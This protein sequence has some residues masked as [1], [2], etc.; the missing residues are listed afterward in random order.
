M[1]RLA[2]FH[3]SLLKLNPRT[4]TVTKNDWGKRAAVTIRREPHPS[5]VGGPQAPAEDSTGRLTLF[6]DERLFRPAPIRPHVPAL[7][8]VT[9]ATLPDSPPQPDLVRA[10]PAV[11]AVVRVLPGCADLVRLSRPTGDFSTVAMS[12]E[13]S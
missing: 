4:L 5:S 2:A 3:S 10:Q 13:I 9:A 11:C 12:N 8:A 1:E 7:S 6:V